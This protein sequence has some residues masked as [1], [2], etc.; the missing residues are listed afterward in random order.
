[1]RT[2]T[3]VAAKWSATINL[4][5]L[6]FGKRRSCAGQL[7]GVL[8]VPQLEFAPEVLLV[9]G[10]LNGNLKVLRVGPHDLHFGVAVKQAILKITRAIYSVFLSTRLLYITA[11]GWDS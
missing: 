9:R 7:A 2:P 4:H 5:R 11:Q 8:R 3:P 1:M 6:S 10:L